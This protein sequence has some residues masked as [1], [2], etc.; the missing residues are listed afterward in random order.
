MRPRADRAVPTIFSH[1][2]VAGVI[3]R[4]MS[5]A[6]PPA[7]FWVLGIGSAMLPDADVAGLYVGIPFGHMLGHRGLSHSLPFAAVVGPLIGSLAFR[8]ARWAPLRARYCMYFALAMASHG[9][10]DAFTAGGG[11]IAF[12]A[13]FSDERYFAPWRPIAV[14]PI[15]VTRFFSPRGFEVMKSELLWLWIPAVAIL[16]VL[17]SLMSAPKNVTGR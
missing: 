3:G 10:L 5:G 6:R 11:G 13:P 15:G 4:A 17:W 2:L 9:V 16:V 8:G 12:F 1:A 7:R 14:S